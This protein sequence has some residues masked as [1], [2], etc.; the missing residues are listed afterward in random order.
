M[1]EYSV[2]VKEVAKDLGSDISL[3]LTSEKVRENIAKYGKNLIS[4]KKKTTLLKRIMKALAEPMMI[5][6]LFALAITFGV[7]IGKFFKDGSGSFYEC[8]GILLSIAVSVTLTVVME[9]KSQRA[10]DFLK[11]VGDSSVVK[12]VRNGEVTVISHADLVVGD[13]VFASAGDKIFADGRI[14]SCEGLKTDES[15]LTGESRPVKKTSARL[16][17]DNVPLAERKNMV[18]SGSYVSEGSVKY[19]VTA[20]GDGA[21][22]GKVAG[23]VGDEKTVSAPLREKLDRLGK[24]VS[25]FGLVCAVFVFVLSLVRLI[26]LDNVT[27]DSVENIFIESI[28]LIVAAVPEGL[29]TTVAISLTLNVVRLARS[30]ALIKKLV[31]TET[32]GCVSVICSD[33]TGT[34]TQNKMLVEEFYTADGKRFRESSLSDSH[35]I[36]N[37]AVNSTAEFDGEKVFG[38]GTEGALII[39]LQK[40]GHDYKTMRKNAKILN[41]EPFSSDKKYMSTTVSVGGKT[42]KYVK[43]AP[44]VI[45]KTCDVDERKKAKIISLIERGQNEGKRA[46]AFSHDEGEGNVFD[47]F[48]LIGDKLRD[49]IERSVAQCT[50]AGIRVKIMT[51]DSLNT[52]VAIAKKLSLAAGENNVV[53]ATELERMTDDEIKSRLP[54]IT[55]VARSTPQTKLKIV[56]LLQETGEV[57]AVTGDGVNDAPAIKHADIG[58]CMGGGSEIT[59]EASDVVLLDDSFDTILTAISFGRNIFENFQRFIAFQLNVNLASIAI[60]LT[61][62]VLGLESPFSSMCL[63]WLN[64]IMD[65]PLA[66]SL[67]LESRPP[68]LTGKKP[69]RRN[70]DI[71]SKRILLRIALHSFFMCLIVT[72]QELYNFLGVAPTEK[73]TVTI[74]MF[75]F[76]QLFNAVNCRE[77]RSAS[78]LKGIFDNKLLSVMI[79]VTFALHIVIVSFL[80]EFF[81]TV[82]LSPV[83]WVKLTL[84]CSSVLVFSELYKLVYR[85]LSAR[86]GGKIAKFSIMKRGKVT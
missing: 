47:G 72:M 68:E 2:D 32:I 45:L 41:V 3:G 4:E 67:S 63:L 81:G 46:L 71:L 86:T 10:F 34:L 64:V 31:A 84:V 58:I 12:T 38:S 53:S 61:Y 27:F 8:L 85:L 77:V 20:V 49:G 24:F 5:I 28:V 13:V 43:G 15:G 52:A 36:Y 76:F 37:C 66:L 1:P 79:L 9:G 26:I 33:K 69:V 25:V 44:E 83:L 22:I 19:I 48:A 35:L 42:V 23:F 78:A 6:L 57:V 21:E 29:P 75:V 16:T 7:N 56:T 54:D 50:A 73:T 82:R 11:T 60:I 14:I 70:S 55:V 18:Y 59:K 39:A 65:G 51:G 80:P 17:G 40:S 30:N 62:L 74:T